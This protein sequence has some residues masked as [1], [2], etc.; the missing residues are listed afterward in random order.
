[1]NRG[2]A[3]VRLDR[4][5]QPIEE[6]GTCLPNYCYTSGE[7]LQIERE[8]VFA[9]TWMLA[10]FQHDIPGRGDLQPATV[11]GVPLMLL[12]D[13]D[14]NVRCFH[15]VC[16]HR[17]AILVDRPR[18]G[19]GVVKCPYHAWTYGLDGRLLARPHFY[20]G[21]R[22]DR[23]ADDVDAPALVPVRLA[24][25]HDLVFVNLS[26]DAPAFEEHMNLFF[27]KTAPYDLTALRYACTVSFDIAA[28]WKLVYENY[29]DCYHIFAAHP[30]LNAF[31]DMSGRNPLDAEGHW[32]WT[33][34]EFYEP[35]VGR[36][37]GLPYYPGLSGHWR[38]TCT[39]FHLFPTACIHIWPDQLAL[40]HHREIAPDRT[41]EDIHLY[42]IGDAATEPRFAAAREGVT[43]LWR[44]LNGEDIGV[45][46]RMQQG[47][48][49]PG[50]DG[51]VLSP[52]WDLPTQ[53]FSRLVADAV[54]TEATA[55]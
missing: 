26:G 3:T 54:L 55:E 21:G 11:A 16:R 13:R 32:L 33:R 6:G 51:G 31:A 1:M 15:N 19:N 5:S 24:C 37:V 43:E 10:G 8:R 30:R 17:G 12:R 52:Y 41:R 22:H 4:T 53:H 9:R 42:F 49:S 38:N 40:L 7:W 14:G 2:A 48:H 20:G 23:I 44:E 35:E 25:L 46:E 18:R 47:R 45:V 29:I 34:Y 39:A 28:N 50:F 36:G 27:E